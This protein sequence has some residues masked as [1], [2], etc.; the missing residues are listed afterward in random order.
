MGGALCGVLPT[1]VSGGYVLWAG[2]RSVGGACRCVLA[3]S[4]IDLRFV[5]GALL[6][7]RNRDLGEEV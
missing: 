7:G 3:E 1:S 2:L 5:G 4:R 6:G